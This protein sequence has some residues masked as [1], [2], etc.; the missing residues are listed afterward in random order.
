MKVDQKARPEIV[1]IRQRVRPYVC[2][3]ILFR[4]LCRNLMGNWTMSLFLT[5]HE[6]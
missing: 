1:T 5:T 6:I 2:P 4:A 3:R